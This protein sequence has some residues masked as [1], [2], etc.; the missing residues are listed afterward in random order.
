MYTHLAG[1]TAW[2]APETFIESEKGHIASKASDV[3]MLGS[4]FVE[5]L[6]G[7]ER[8]PFDWLSPSQTFIFRARAHKSAGVEN[9]LQV[10]VRVC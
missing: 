5:L 9:C 4:C 8:M 2:M 7:C 1:P 6:T 3:Y 10:L